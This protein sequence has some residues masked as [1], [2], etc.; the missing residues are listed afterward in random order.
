M[1]CP[2]PID[3]L[4]WLENGSS[5]PSLAEH[6]ET[7][8][9]CRAVLAALRAGIPGSLA[10]SLDLTESGPQAVPLEEVVGVTPATGDVWVTAAPEEGLN[11]AL[12]LVL[13]DS[14]PEFGRDWYEIAA[15]RTDVENAIEI[16]LLL[17]GNESSLGMPFAVRFD[18]QGY[19]AASDL[20]ER[21]GALTAS[22][23]EVILRAR[24]GLVDESRWGLPIE[25]PED[26]RLTDRVRGVPA[27]L[28]LQLLYRA[29]AA[30]AEDAELSVAL[31]VKDARNRQHL[32]RAELAERLAGALNVTPLTAK[33]KRH[34][35]D[36]ENGSLDPRRLRPALV[37][38]LSRLLAIPRQQ[39]EG[40][41]AAWTSPSPKEASSVFARAAAGTRAQVEA[42]SRTE[43]DAVDDLFLGGQE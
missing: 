10:A 38:E 3:W 8:V 31:L 14:H 29:R 11:S 22:G 32:T 6:A 43:R 28:Q 39:L 1:A 7:C 34:Y 35:A 16:D 33:V 21:V 36:L 42:S 40:I 5:N 15:A 2:L 37:A 18:L 23:R 30:A 26:R 24:D 19:V 25:G 13:G 4:D 41:G 27:V 20:R 12:V 17:H 9:S